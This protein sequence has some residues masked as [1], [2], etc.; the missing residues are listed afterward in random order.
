MTEKKEQ[1]RETDLK[2]QEE[3]VELTGSHLSF[4]SVLW[5]S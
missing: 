3:V 2:K 5:W 4:P 1:N